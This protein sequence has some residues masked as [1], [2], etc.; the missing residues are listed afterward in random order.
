MTYWETWHG[1]YADPDSSLSR[2]LRVVQDQVAHWLDAT[3][4]G[5]VRVVSL[6]AGDG[7]DLLEVLAGRD[8][9]DRVTATLV[10]LD[11]HLAGRA[12]D[13]ARGWSGVEVLTADAGDHDVYADLPP[14]DLVLLCGVLG[15]IS[16]ADVQHTIA[17]LPALCA[18]DAR[19]IWTRTRRAP[20]I[21]PRV[22]TWFAEHGFRE[23]SFI[24]ISD[25]EAAVGVADL[26][27][28]PGPALGSG[29]LFTFVAASSN[30]CTLA[31]YERRADR[32]DATLGSAP[33]WHVAFLDRIAAAVPPGAAVLEL[34]SGTGVD[35]RYL[36]D[37]GLAVQ[38]SDGA[39]SFV[40]AMRHAGLAPLHIDVLTDGLGGPWDAVVAFAM[41]LHLTPD[42]LATV[43]DRIHGAVRARGTL[44]LSVK[45]GD[46]S[47]WSDHKLGLPRFF[48]YWRPDPLA[49]L[50]DQHGWTVDV[51]ERHAGTRDDWILV[52]ATR[53]DDDGVRLNR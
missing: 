17:E 31:V 28:D 21:T 46:G 22:R 12:R 38:P 42:E 50:L 6:C 30:A 16:D 5:P 32:Y 52:I 9:A 24:P 18:P 41:L 48:T 1:A 7:R 27:D 26:A 36:A 11:P 51:L 40:D 3:A 44:A 49:R 47:A 2:R 29:R 37:L 43:L 53:R 8:D 23:V 13:R 14:A 35:A 25:S 15:N 45:E 19:V 4:P 33:D 34:G 10:E 39:T 20:D